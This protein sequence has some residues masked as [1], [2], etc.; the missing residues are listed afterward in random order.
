MDGWIDGWGG[1]KGGEDGR[2][3]VDDEKGKEER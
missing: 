3:K 1:E 2:K